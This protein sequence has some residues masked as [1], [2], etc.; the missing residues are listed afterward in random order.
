MTRNLPWKGILK[1]I[2]ERRAASRRR[3]DALRQL[4]KY[5]LNE[6]APPHG[7]PARLIVSLTSYPR[8]FGTLHLTIKSLLDQSVKPDHVILWIDRWAQGQIPPKVAGLE[9]EFFSI[10]P[11]DDDLRSFNKIVPTLRGHPDAFI[12]IADDDIYYPDFWLERLIATYDPAQ[13]T[14]VYHRGHRIAYCR[15][16]KL[17]PYDSWTRSVRDD[18]SLQ[19]STDIFPTGVGGVLYPPNSL[20]PLAADAKLLKQ[21]SATCDDSWL[22]FMWRQTP[23]KAKR[24]AGR[25]PRFVEWPDSQQNSLQS[26]HAGGAKDVHLRA[27]S[28]YF[29][30]P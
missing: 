17:A 24:V 7:L 15:E 19:P 25:M 2:R 20:P 11:C 8:R 1:D 23:W 29:G 13:P 10:C 14:I 28:E 18:A 16:G 27:L 12:A 22:Y 30:T 4:R 26:F 9:G 3:S 6:D 5:P 21:L